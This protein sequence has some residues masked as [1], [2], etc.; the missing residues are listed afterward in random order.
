[1][2]KTKGVSY[3]TKITVGQKS[4][5]LYFNSLKREEVKVE[6]NSKEGKHILH[7]DGFSPF[8]NRLLS[9]K[10]LMTGSYKQPWLLD[11]GTFLSI[12]QCNSCLEEVLVI[13]TA[14]A[15]CYQATDRPSDVQ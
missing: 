9:K 4:T 12:W 6:L 3:I 10:K 2:V 1:M 7:N 5:S 14:A 15:C 11:P 13:S 8:S